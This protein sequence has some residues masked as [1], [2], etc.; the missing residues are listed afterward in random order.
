MPGMCHARLLRSPHPHA[1]IRSIDTS[2]ARRA[3]GVVAVVT[4]ADLPDVE[5]FF[6]HAVRDHP[7]IA[8]DKVR[9]AGEPVVGVVAETVL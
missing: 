3:P 6:G 7:L 9:Y 1:R 4:A 2:A 8:V 5:L